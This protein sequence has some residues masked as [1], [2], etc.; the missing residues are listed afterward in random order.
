MNARGGFTL[1]ELMVAL[2]VAGALAAVAYPGYQLHVIRTK[3]TEAQ[4]ALQ[5]VMHQQE[6]YFT[7]NNRYVAFGAGVD[8]PEARL[9]RWWSGA[10][11]A[12]SAYEI[13]GR[14]CG[15]E[16]IADCV[17]L[18]A[19]PGTDRVDNRYRD[20]SCDRLILTSTG[21]HLATGPATRCWR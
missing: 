14:A 12:A 2:A 7:Q 20:P 19:I 17:E 1:V 21:M 18:V 5:A 13:I 6:R 10:T 11:P 8:G 9:F 16:D 4:V 15:S 3:R